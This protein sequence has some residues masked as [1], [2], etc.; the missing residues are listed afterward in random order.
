MATYGADP[1]EIR[2]AALDSATTE[3][4]R[5]KWRVPDDWVSGM[6]LTITWLAAAPGAGAEAVRW[7]ID[8]AYTDDN[9]SAVAAGT[10]VLFTG[11][12]RVR[13]ANDVQVEAAQAIATGCGAGKIVRVTIK[14][15][16]GDAADTLTGD[17]AL[18]SARFDYTG[19]Q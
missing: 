11:V 18:L 7:S 14:R 12:S 2:G 3:R 1:N 13:S 19:E 5:F 17:A 9:A 10:N 8:Y 15:I 4:I 16:G 6:S